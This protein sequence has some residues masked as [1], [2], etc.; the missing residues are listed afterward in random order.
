M[1]LFIYRQQTYAHTNTLSIPF[2]SLALV[3]LIPQSVAAAATA[4]AVSASAST[5]TIRSSSENHEWN[6][7]VWRHTDCAPF[8]LR[9]FSFALCWCWFRCCCDSS[10]WNTLSAYVYN[11]SPSLCPF[12]VPIRIYLYH[13]RKHLIRF[14]LLRFAF[15]MRSSFAT[16]KPT[17]NFIHLHWTIRFYFLCVTQHHTK[18]SVT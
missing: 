13:E 8:C 3:L 11:G 15:M 16:P 5:T 14:I 12:S 1:Y 10:W 2:W 9:I 6:F 4:S 18:C 7:S 17:Q